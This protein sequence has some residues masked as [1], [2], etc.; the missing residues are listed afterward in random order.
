VRP[1]DHPPRRSRRQRGNAL[2]EFAIVLPLML[3]LLMGILDYGW[4]LV[5]YLAASNGAREAARS[6]TT[7]AGSCPNSSAIAAGSAAATRGLG[8]LGQAGYASV[9]ATC[10]S[11]P[12]IADPLFQFDVDV[13]FPRLTGLPLIPMPSAGGAYPG[14]F[15]HVHTRAVMRGSR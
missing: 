7:Y 9:T 12:G 2:V 11:A 15:I 14:N 13:N 3:T 10:T 5:V 1:V 6:A 8:D 4:Y